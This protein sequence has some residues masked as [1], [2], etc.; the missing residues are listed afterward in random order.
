M[1]NV[2]KRVRGLIIRSGPPFLSGERGEDSALL[3]TVP[4][5]SCKQERGGG[6]V[7]ESLHSYG[8]WHGISSGKKMF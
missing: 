2:F 3:V 5:A 1:H 4:L 7:I 6:A 8:Y